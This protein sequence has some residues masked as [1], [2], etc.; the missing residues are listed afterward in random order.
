ME[1]SFINIPTKSGE[2]RDEY[3][4]KK[5]KQKAYQIFLFAAGLAVILTALQFVN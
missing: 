1:Q 5:D 4:L 3:S 2:V